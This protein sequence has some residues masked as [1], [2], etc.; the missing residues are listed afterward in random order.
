MKLALTQE[1][2]MVE[3]GPG[4]PEQ[5]ECPHCGNVVDLRYRKDS[6]TWFWRHRRKPPG[7][8]PPKEAEANTEVASVS[9]ETPT[10]WMLGANL[11]ELVEIAQECGAEV[12]TLALGES[13]ECDGPATVI[14]ARR[15]DK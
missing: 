7:G 3:A 12:R 8:C 5:A 14:V 6:S 1:K 13:F 4:A 10:G 2:Q 15:Y 9:E 11:D